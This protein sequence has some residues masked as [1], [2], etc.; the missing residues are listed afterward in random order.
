MRKPPKR[1]QLPARFDRD[2][3][4]A[5]ID[6]WRKEC[7]QRVANRRL[8]LGASR[9]DVADLAGSDVS[10]ITRIELGQINATDRLRVTLAAV[11][12]CDVDDL[13]HYPSTVAGRLQA[14]VEA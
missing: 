10:T 5:L 4:V 8:L 6:E 14:R 1:P 13:W 9:A 7:G 2:A 11:L 3:V 12:L